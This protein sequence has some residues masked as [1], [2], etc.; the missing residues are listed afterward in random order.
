MRNYTV[1]MYDIDGLLIKMFPIS[2]DNTKVA[3]K[4]VRFMIKTDADV[5]PKDWHHW[6]VM[7]CK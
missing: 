1:Y 3:E 5:I 2:A 4:M 6:Q 7:E